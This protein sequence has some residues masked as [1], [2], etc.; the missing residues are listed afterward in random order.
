VKAGDPVAANAFFEQV[1][2]DPVGLRTEPTRAAQGNGLMANCRTALPLIMR[3]ISGPGTLAS[4]KRS[5]GIPGARGIVVRVAPPTR[6]RL[7]NLAAV[8]G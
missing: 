7:Q 4:R 6:P 2:I 3:A 8:S 5:Q 1:S